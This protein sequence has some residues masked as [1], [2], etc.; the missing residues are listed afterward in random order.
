MGLSD[1]AIILSILFL[2]HNVLN[3]VIEVKVSESY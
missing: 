2:H 1:V 3:I